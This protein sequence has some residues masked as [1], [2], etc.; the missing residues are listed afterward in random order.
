MVT[1]NKEQVAALL[2]VSTKTVQRYQE[3]KNDP[4]PFKKTPARIVYNPNEV[5]NWAIHQSRKSGLQDLTQEEIDHDYEKARLTKE[6]ATKEALR[7]AQ[8]RNE[9]APIDIL[10]WTINKVGG[11]IS[12]ILSAVPLKIKRRIPS[13]TTSDVEMIKREIVKAQN[14]ASKITI[15]LDE[16]SNNN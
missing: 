14:A 2:D 6:Q 11:Q 7:N 10:Q 12:S 5:L 3:R 8:L 4:I 15:D 9:L 1:F 13:L 16:Y